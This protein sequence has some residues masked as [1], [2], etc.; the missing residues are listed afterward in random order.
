MALDEN[1]E[2]HSELGI[3]GYIY[4]SAP[5]ASPPNASTAATRD[6]DH[7]V[8]DESNCEG[9]KVEAALGFILVNP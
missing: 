8:S 7:F 4:P 1:C 9:V 5:T 2:G 6:K 3:N